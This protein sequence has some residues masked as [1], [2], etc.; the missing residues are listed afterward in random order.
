MQNNPPIS[1]GSGHGAL[2]F[3]ATDSLSVGAQHTVQ[4]MSRKSKSYLI[5]D[6]EF[7]ALE[8]VATVSKMCWSVIAISVSMI[9]SALWDMG[10]TRDGDGWFCFGWVVLW[11]VVCGTAVTVLI[12]R[13]ERRAMYIDRIKRESFDPASHS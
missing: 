8:E 3:R 9:L 11:G 4:N 1:P 5:N 13:R 7:D 6:S 2:E 12:R 10:F